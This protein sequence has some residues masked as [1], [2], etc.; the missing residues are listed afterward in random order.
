M[1]AHLLR[2]PNLLQEEFGDLTVADFCGTVHQSLF[3][4][5]TKLTEEGKSFDV[6]TVA[7]SWG[8]EKT[9]GRPDCLS[10]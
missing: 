7:E 10:F 9:S 5:I 2:E 1:L 8:A 4:T 6:V 3:R